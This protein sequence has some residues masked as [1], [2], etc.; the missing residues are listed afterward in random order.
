MTGSMLFASLLSLIMDHSAGPSCSNADS[1]RNRQSSDRLRQSSD[2]SPNCTSS[3]ANALSKTLSSLKEQLSLTIWTCDP[4]ATLDTAFFDLRN[5]LTL[6]LGSRFWDFRSM[7]SSCSL[8]LS[9]CCFLPYSCISR[10][11]E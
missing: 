8:L 2:S 11:S 7:S 10:L 6:S 4:M 3:S 1:C 9:T 5:E